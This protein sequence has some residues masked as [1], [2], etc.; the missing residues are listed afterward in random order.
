M[1][2]VQKKL[3]STLILTI[4]FFTCTVTGEDGMTSAQGNNT[5]AFEIY[6]KVAVSGENIFLSPFSTSTALAMTYLGARGE[7]AEEMAKVLHFNTNQDAFHNDYK[8]LIDRIS[9]LGERKDV[10]LKTANSLWLQKRYRIK[11]SFLD[12]A[13]KYYG[14]KV[15][16]VNFRETEDAR[17]QINT[18]TS[19]NTEGKIKELLKPGLLDPLTRLVLVNAIYF[20]GSW[21]HPFDAKET[22]DYPF[23]LYPDNVI[24]TPTMSSKKNFSFYKDEDIKMVALPYKGG[25][26]SLIAV[27][28]HDIR[29]IDKLE[30]HIT[31]EMFEK[32]YGKLESKEVI[33]KLPRFKI[34]TAKSLTG[35]L[36]QLGLSTPFSQNADFTGMTRKKELY[37]SDVVHEAFVDVNEKGTEAAA[38]TAVAMRAYA[39]PPDQT[40]E[41]I[42]NH[43]FMFFIYDS[44]SK[45]ILFMGKVADPTR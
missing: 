40:E 27:L 19:D 5:L 30:E 6:K 22:R 8:K 37:I 29:G 43:P 42:A 15:N 13:E 38:A 41:F 14:P 20:K 34:R 36:K 18:W 24:Q 26:I 28:P 10:A 11:S 2:R 21:A 35:P 16:L 32:W 3:L 45:S 4:F 17:N 9:E 23:Y 25:D 7:T 31:A 39:L 33:L 1:K 44:T 12:D